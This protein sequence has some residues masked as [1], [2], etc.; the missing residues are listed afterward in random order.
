MHWKFNRKLFQRLQRNI[1]DNI[2]SYN[3]YTYNYYVE[4]VV[5]YL[6]FYKVQNILLTV[7][8]GFQPICKFYNAA[9]VTRDRRIGSWIFQFLL[10]PISRKSGRR[11]GLSGTERRT[12]AALSWAARRRRCRPRRRRRSGLGSDGW[13]MLWLRVKIDKKWRKLLPLWLE[14]KLF[15][16]K[17]HI[18]DF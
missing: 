5:A 4:E 17:N 8:L 3:H 2:L 16:H 1:A 12:S 10:Y 18:I 15:M 7:Y 14:V 9:V 6:A 11:S 13:S